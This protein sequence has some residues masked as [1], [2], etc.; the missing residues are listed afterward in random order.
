MSARFR[1]AP[2][3][4]FNDVGFRCLGKGV[5]RIVCGFAWVKLSP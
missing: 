3:D 4:T 1:F 2:A 5:K